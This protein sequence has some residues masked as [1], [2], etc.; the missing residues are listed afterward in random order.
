MASDTDRHTV[1]PVRP[2]DSRAEPVHVTV[3]TGGGSPLRLAVGL[4]AVLL[5]TLLAALGVARLFDWSPFGSTDRDRSGPVVLTALRDLSEYHASSGSYQ[6]L[7]DLEQDQRYVPAVIK[8]RRTLFLAIGSV[9]SYV[10]FGKLDEK[11]VSVSSDR[12][13][14]TITLRHAQLG[15]AVVDPDQSR[16][17][18]RNLGLID[19]LGDLFGDRTHAQEQQIYGLAERKLTDAA[20]HGGLVA[21]AEANTRTTLD[22]LLKALGF[23]DV[24]VDFADRAAGG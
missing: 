23:T 10:D 13:S 21:R 7:I 14:V 4:V 24:R 17:L 15:R 9:D 12:R 16:V 8:G 20:K 2:D 22:R 18:D 5:V 1:D 11:A 19:R 6:I 3:R